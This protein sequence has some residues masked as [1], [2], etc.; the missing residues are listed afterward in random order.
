MGLSYSATTMRRI[1]L[2]VANRASDCVTAQEL[3][4]WTIGKAA[5]LRDESGWHHIAGLHLLTRFPRAPLK[6]QSL[7]YCLLGLAP[8]DFKTNRNFTAIR[9]CQTCIFDNLALVQSPVVVRGSN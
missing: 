3:C 1:S 8:F 5:T 6:W 9:R 2:P 7:S 4:R